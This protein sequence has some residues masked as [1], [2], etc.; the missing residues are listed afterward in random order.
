MHFF[1]QVAQRIPRGKGRDTPIGSRKLLG[2]NI[3]TFCEVGRPLPSTPSPGTR[4]RQ[5][6]RA[7]RRQLSAWAA[8]PGGRFATSPPPARL[9]AS[10]LGVCPPHPQ[11]LSILEDGAPPATSLLLA[12]P[13]PLRLGGHRCLSRPRGF[14]QHLSA[15]LELSS[16]KV[17]RRKGGRERGKVARRRLERQRAS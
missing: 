4:A 15:E 10:P 5:G 6:S 13:G 9:P 11:Y 1:L 7:H 8:W 12:V 2:R 16:G 3:S 17:W 14:M